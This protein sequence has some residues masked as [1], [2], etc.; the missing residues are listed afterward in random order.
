VSKKPQFR[1]AV[2]TSAPPTLPISGTFF[3]VAKSGHLLTE[4]VEIEVRD[5]YV[6]GFKVISRAPDLAQSAVA[7][8]QRRIWEVLRKQSREEVLGGD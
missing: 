4:A 3:T 6:V 8:C 7:V 5:G 2:A 1:P